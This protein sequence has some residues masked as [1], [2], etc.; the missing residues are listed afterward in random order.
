MATE[1][2]IAPGEARS[3]RSVVIRSYDR[4]EDA[5]RAVDR[6]ADDGFAV[7]RLKVAGE[8][9]SLV[10]QV[11]GRRTF[12][13]AA[14]EGAVAGAI[15]TGLLGVVFGLLNWFDPLISALALGLY[16]VVFG[17]AVGSIVGLIG[18][19]M[20][21]GERDFSSRRT[22]TAQRFDLLADDDIADDARMRLAA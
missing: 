15:I 7:E 13:R 19:A 22:L 14:A 2:L 4:Y 5:Q 11:T 6:L 12:Q 20:T 21:S 17:A 18:F 10:E 9:L 1:T 3:G 8:D 16:G